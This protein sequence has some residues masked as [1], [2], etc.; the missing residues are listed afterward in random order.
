MRYFQGNSVQGPVK[1]SAAK[2]FREVVDAFRICPT[3]GIARPA[4]LALDKKQR[5]EIKQVPFFVPACFN[6][7]P[8]KR[9]Y[10]EAVHC[11]LI[12]LDIDETADGKCPAAPF[13]HNPDS[14]YTALEGLNFAAHTTASSTPQ[15]PRMRV[16]V[17]AEAIPVASYAQAVATIG[18]MLGLVKLTTESKVAVQPMFL[19]TLFSDS[20]DDEHPLIAHRLDGRAF[21]EDDISD[22]APD[23]NEPRSRSVGVAEGS[24]DSLFF[25]RAPVPEINL[26]VAKEALSHIDPDCSYFEWLEVAAAL[27]HQFSP[28]KSEEAYT[29]FDEWSS[30]GTKYGGTEDTAAK[31]KS[32]RPS[33]NG[34]LP[35]TI[36]SL[37]RQ[38]VASGWDDKKVKDNCF[39]GLL[40]WMEEAETFTELI[41]HGAQKIMSAPLLSSMQ[42]STL[43][44]RL[45]AEA[46]RRFAFSISSTSVHKDIAKMKKSIKAQEKPAEKLKEPKWAKGTLYVSAAQEFF[47]HRTGERYKAEPFNAIYSRHLL[48]TAEALE[49]AGMPVNATTLSRPILSPSDYALNH[50]KIP[51]VYDYAYDPSQPTEMWFVSRGRKYVN[52]Y[53]PTYPELDAENAEEAGRLFT[54]HLQH[55]IAEEDYRRTLVDFL[56]SMVQT[57]GR[58][59]RW[60][61]LIQ[62]VEG[63][64]KT[65]IAEVMKAV[66]GPEHVRTLDGASIKKGWTEWAFGKQ[67]VVLEEVRVSGTNKHEIMNTLKPFITNDDITVNE[68]NRNTRETPNISNYLMFSNHHDA[69]ALS[70][71]DRRYFVIKSPLQHKAQVLALGENYFPPLYAMLRDRA[72]AMRAWLSEWEISP[73][74][75]PDGHAPRTK[76]VN[77]MVNDSAT[78]LTAAVRRLLLEA[79]HP[80]IQYDIVSAKKLMDVLQVEEGLGGVTVQ[81]LAQCLREEGLYQAGRHMFGGERQYLWV[82][83]GVDATAAPAIATERE[84]KGSKNLNM[85]L[86]FS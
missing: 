69:L 28:H 11:N 57:P 86:I 68:R 7:S 14:L 80:L 78:S 34:R 52:T 4:F 31:W 49:E 85:E 36:R 25:L 67:L 5:N 76:Y 82:R 48:P 30:D 45:C 84:K 54:F 63:A 61:V 70:P 17:D 73:D 27:R 58:K 2:N 47:R 29:L 22:T 62:S 3:L 12:F 44:N 26:V 72:G 33:P 74:F 19:P 55:L 77:D 32:L 66:L 60:A 56:A 15:K 79:D 16:V 46:K 18:A 59:I 50:L 1:A 24:T 51:T 53:T 41:D 35:I 13:V 6:A 42:E 10:A 43:V 9:I 65:Y 71:G 23:Y 21:T 40:R 83:N 39:N 38:A 75:R 37:L 20:G 64:G 8:S 81:Q